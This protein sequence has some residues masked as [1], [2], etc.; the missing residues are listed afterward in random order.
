M[1]NTA[2]NT[3]AST[4]TIN[5]ICNDPLVAYANCATTSCPVC[6]VPSQNSP[7]GGVSPMSRTALGSPT[8]SGPT[9]PTSTTT[10]MSPNPTASLG[11]Q[12]G[13][14]RRLLSTVDTSAPHPLTRVR[15][16]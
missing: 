9:S 15:G 4:P 3:V 10:P 2:D 12:R 6:V 16:S 1:P 11:D 5:P 13:R 8:T 7:P 14:T